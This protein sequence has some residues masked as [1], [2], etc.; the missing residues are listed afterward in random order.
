MVGVAGSTDVG[1]GGGPDSITAEVVDGAG[2]SGGPG[3]TVHP[4]DSTSP[5]TEPAPQPSP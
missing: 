2:S 5:S 1:A 4:A 3:L